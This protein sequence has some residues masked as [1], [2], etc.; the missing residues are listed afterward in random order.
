MDV[1]DQRPFKHGICASQGPSFFSFVCLLCWFKRFLFAFF[2]NFE[3]K[4]ENTTLAG[5]LVVTLRL[6]LP[7]PASANKHLALLTPP[8]QMWA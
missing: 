4:L 2:L 6:S 8:L 3:K 5:D 1:S 7:E